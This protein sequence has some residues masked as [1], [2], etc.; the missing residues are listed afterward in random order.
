MFEARSFIHLSIMRVPNSKRAPLGEISS[1]QEAKFMSGFSTKIE[2][3]FR[4]RQS[5]AE[6]VRL[7]GKSGV[8]YCVVEIYNSRIMLRF[9]LNPTQSK[10]EKVLNIEPFAVNDGK[11]HSVVAYR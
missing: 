8:T 11:W 5:H 9:N 1:V 7:Q 3:S 10:G 2:F 6:M 4:T